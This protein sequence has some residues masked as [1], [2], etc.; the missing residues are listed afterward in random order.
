MTCL[1]GLAV[2][3]YPYFGLR[4]QEGKLTEAARSVGVEDAGRDA[5]ARQDIGG[6]LGVEQRGCDVNPLHQRV[7]RL[8]VLAARVR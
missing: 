6:K 3:I 1:C 8:R 7:R 2:V 5:Q 4:L